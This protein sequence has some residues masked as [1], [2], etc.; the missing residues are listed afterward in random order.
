M[1]F[2]KEININSQTYIVKLGLSIHEI[3]VGAQKFNKLTLVSYEM[4]INRYFLHNL[5]ENVQ[6]FEKTFS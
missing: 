6:F 5:L 3:N 4:V 1:N 2:G